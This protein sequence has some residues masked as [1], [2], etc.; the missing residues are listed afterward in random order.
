MKNIL[1]IASL[2]G[3]SS[4]MLAIG[5]EKTAA[6]PQSAYSPADIKVVGTIDSGQTSKPVEYSA[7]PQYRALVFEA[8]GNDQVQVKVTGLSAN[9]YVALADSS[10]KPIASG[11][12]E[13]TATLPYVGPDI[14]TYYILFKDNSNQP[15]KLA[16]HL[17]RIAAAA[18]V[19]A[20][21]AT[22]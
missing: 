19:P 22:H 20:A 1:L 14:D 11:T 6:D 7:T 9:A 21:N 3:L 8:G 2:Y 15:A 12:G 18:V 16:V 4:G 13:L 10:L 17:N 5:Q